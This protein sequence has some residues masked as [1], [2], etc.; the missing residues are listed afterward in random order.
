MPTLTVESQEL[1]KKVNFVRTAL[2]NSKTDLAIILMRCEVKGN[3][4][5]LFAASKEL[6]A[7]ASFRVGRN[8]GDEDGSFTLLGSKLVDLTSRTEAEKITLTWDKENLEAVAGYLTVNFELYDDVTIRTT[9]NAVTPMLETKGS[10]VPK[11]ALEEALV[12]ARSCTTATAVRPDVTHAELRNGRM[13]SSDGRKIMIYTHDAF[14]TDQNLKV[15]ASILSSVVTAVKNAD[16]PALELAEAEAYYLIKGNGTEYALGVRKTERSFP[17]VED[18]ITAAAA[19]TDEVAI[20]KNVLESMLRGVCMGLPSDEVKITFIVAGTGREATLECSALNQLGR[21][22]W[23]RSSV[24]R[25]G[26]DQVQLPISYKHM[27]DTLSVFK[28]D[29]VV[30]LFVMNNQ[31]LLMVKDKTE[32]REVLTIIPFRTDKQIEQEKAEAAVLAEQRKKETAA[33]EA[34]AAAAPELVDAAI[35][36]IDDGDPLADNAGGDLDLED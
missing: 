8:E 23:E 6:F 11:D 9:E 26:T 14:T 35:G 33:D 36:D 31:Q 3:K 34:E 7:K 27:L 18:Q 28:G 21:R 17:Q 4:A 13:L 5:T 25:K 22:S 24:G 20:D 29:S 10:A 1:R 30:D 2:G 32:A 16:I 15:P 19:P 12:C